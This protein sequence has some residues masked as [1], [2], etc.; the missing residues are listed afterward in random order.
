MGPWTTVAVFVFVFV[1]ISTAQDD[2]YSCARVQQAFVQKGLGS[3]RIIPNMPISGEN[4]KVC[5]SSSTCCTKRVEE[6][7][8]QQAKVDFQNAVQSESAYTKFLISTNAVKYQEEFDN[9]IVD[10]EE[11]TTKVV[12]EMYHNMAIQA[13]AIIPKFYENLA[14]YVQGKEIDL[15]NT[16]IKFFS[17]LF[18][19]VYVYEIHSQTV[20]TPDYQECLNDVT[21]KVK[22]FGNIPQKVGIHLQKS[23]EAARVFIQALNLGIEVINTTD[24]I[25]LTRE[26]SKALLKLNYCSYCNGVPGIKPCNSFCLNVMK[27]CLATVADVN[28]DWNSYIDQLDQHTMGMRGIYNIQV[29]LSDLA[30]RISDAI[31]HAMDNGP[32]LLEE[33]RKFCGHPPRQK[34]SSVESMYGNTT[35]SFPVAMPPNLDLYDRIRNSVGKLASKKLF[36]KN[37][38]QQL[39]SN[40][41]VAM[42]S[43]YECWIGDRKGRY[44]KNVV[45]DNA[46]DRYIN[47]E[48][49]VSRQ[50][51]QVIEKITDKLRHI[52]QLLK[53]KSAAP[54]E[55]FYTSGSG[56]GDVVVVDT[57]S[58]C[59]GN[60]DMDDEDCEGSG[61]SGAEPD[62]VKSPDI[63]IQEATTEDIEFVFDETTSKN[64]FTPNGE[65]TIVKENPEE[66]QDGNSSAPSLS[67]SIVATIVTI[68]TVFICRR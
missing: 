55:E 18:P 39:C 14:F 32:V 52:Q 16:V 4:L 7:F 48:M 1:T 58:G 66:R 40:D 49:R 43:D 19:L 53:G 68:A 21:E 26:C 46:E 15:E 3:S 41:N 54:G 13:N 25:V 62:V 37:L 44:A 17:E 64:T 51:D 61:G 6:K 9:Y 59:F 2:M 28:A 42:R 12:R 27:G 36:Y 56:D 50:R 47:P 60:S 33:V 38:P 20:L 29:V 45:G 63:A 65:V 35:A 57:G 22:P 30:D 5:I 8:L 23:L 24:Y 34:R 10:A 67:S 11:E 31:M